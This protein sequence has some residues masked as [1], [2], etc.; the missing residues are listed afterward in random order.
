M[1][2]KIFT[3]GMHAVPA[4]LLFDIVR[5]ELMRFAHSDAYF[6]LTFAYRAFC[7]VSIAM[8]FLMI[9]LILALV[10]LAACAQ[11]ENTPPYTPP[12]PIP[13]PV[14][15]VATPPPVSATPY[16]GPNAI[17]TGTPP[18]PK[19]APLVDKVAACAAILDTQARGLCI[20]RAGQN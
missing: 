11:S 15:S 10:P 16:Y 3:V 2:Y 13:P 19:S 17:G 5:Q 6:T 9:A 20:E 4:R 1:F 7:Q 12:P 8:R 14:P 18:L